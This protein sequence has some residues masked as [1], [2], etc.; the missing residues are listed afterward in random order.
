MISQFYSINLLKVIM[1]KPSIGERHSTQQAVTA[2]LYPVN[3][4]LQH[5]VLLSLEVIFQKSNKV[6]EGCWT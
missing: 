6:S 1:E 4:K 2:G 3:R 5:Y